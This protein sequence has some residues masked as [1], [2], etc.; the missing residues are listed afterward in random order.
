M[1]PS[2]RFVVE[3]FPAIGVASERGRLTRAR[4]PR[5]LCADLAERIVQDLPPFAG[6]TGGLLRGDAKTVQLARDVF[7]GAFHLPPERPTPIGEE[8]VAG[9]PS[10]NRTQKRCYQC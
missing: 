10:K 3:R 4:I 5:R 2:S 8:Q 1:R 6:D 9:G 7:D